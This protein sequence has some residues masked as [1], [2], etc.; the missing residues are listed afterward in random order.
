M[1]HAASELDLEPP[2]I[3]TRKI[4][5]RIDDGTSDGEFPGSPEAVHCPIYFQLIDY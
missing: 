4:P 1:L 5:K 2:H 3:P